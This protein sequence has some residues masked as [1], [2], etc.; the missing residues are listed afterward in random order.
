MHLS[1]AA[2]LASAAKFFASDTMQ[3]STRATQPTL[4]VATESKLSALLA[5]QP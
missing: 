2:T 1:L 4:T 3:P 5:V